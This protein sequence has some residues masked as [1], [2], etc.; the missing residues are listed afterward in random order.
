MRTTTRSLACAAYAL[1]WCAL[2]A[3]GS[4]THAH[5]A[6]PAAREPAPSIDRHFAQLWQRGDLQPAAADDA[7]FLRRVYLDLPGHIPTVAEARAFLADNDP[8]KRAK[9]VDR[10][11]DHPATARHLAQFWRRSWLPQADNQQLSQLAEEL[12]RWLAA[13]LAADVSYQQLA[14]QLLLA[15]VQQYRSEGDQELSPN[16]AFLVAAEFRP[17]NL[18][19][20]A[21]RSFLGINLDCAQCHDHPF[22][23]WKRE[24]FWQTAA[25]FVRPARAAEELDTDHYRVT[26]PET[27]LVISARL[28]NGDE[29][30]WPQK[31]ELDSGR[32]VLVDWI[33]A[34]DNPFFARNA[35]NRLWSHFFGQ[36]LIEPLD[37]LSAEGPHLHG[38]LLDELAQQFVLTN[39]QWKPLA[40][41]MVLSRVYQLDSLAAD[42]RCQQAPPE[43]YPQMP[44]RSLSGEQL[45]HSLLIA[46]G[47]PLAADHSAGGDESR[48]AFVGKFGSDRSARSE[49]SILQSLLLMNG[50]LTQELTA[51]DSPL[52]RSVANSPFWTDEKKVEVLF[53]AAYSRPPHDDER[54]LALKTMAAPSQREQAL[55]DLLWALLNSGEF[56]CNH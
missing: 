39:W 29:P 37:D 5:G 42:E 23:R 30:A 55:S 25:F 48:Q 35:V 40:R 18:A 56:N 13:S 27:E 53:L 6:E 1:T 31:M 33:A 7:T 32:R 43:L 44:V 15:D 4:L 50:P 34:S 28:L 16:S 14:R 46:T 41:A 47:K 45:Y 12:E 24:Q 2:A 54:A 10:L 8:H 36:G 52:V 9:L 51:A 11:L 26:I 17:E 21:C 3:L 49:R 22:S 20:N 19:A 38:P